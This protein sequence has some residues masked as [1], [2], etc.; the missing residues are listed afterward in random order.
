MFPGF[1]PQDIKEAIKNKRNNLKPPLPKVRATSMDLFGRI[2]IIF[3]QD[4]MLPQT[5]DQKFWD[6]L[7][8]V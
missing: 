3:D 1:D 7:L 4:I 6:L 5:M 8:E 2:T